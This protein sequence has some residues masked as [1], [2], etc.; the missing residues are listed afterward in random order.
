V[1]E[2]NRENPIGLKGE[3]ARVTATMMISLSGSGTELGYYWQSYVLAWPE[4]PCT[5]K[6][7]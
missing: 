4:A 2:I 1:R 3:L 7:R 6:R 5:G